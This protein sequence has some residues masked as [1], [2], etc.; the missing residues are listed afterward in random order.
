MK[1]S[2]IIPTYNEENIIGRLIKYLKQHG[3]SALA[4]IIVA[5][6]GSDDK[7]FQHASVAGA[8][9]FVSP[10]KGR[11]AQMNYGAQHASG[12]ILY[13]VHADV[14]P[15]A[16]FAT[17]ILKA[18]HEKYDLGRYFMKFDSNKWYLKV[19]AFF[20]RFDFFICYGGDQTLFI[21]RNLYDKAGGFN[22][23]LHIMEDFEFTKRAKNFGRYKIFNKGA[24]ISARKYDK[25]SW[26][27]VQMANKKI[28]S[29]YNN[30]ANQHEMVNTY[31]NMLNY[32]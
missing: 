17:D 9:T 12:S 14:L 3:G 21:T 19:N 7:T 31:R 16:S 2:I 22:P 26:W 4:E 23:R 29:M 27:K 15:P 24:L 18:V 1:I 6:G 5:D 30:G 32:R 13:F 25:N 20:T 28:V 10:E 11:G 8:V